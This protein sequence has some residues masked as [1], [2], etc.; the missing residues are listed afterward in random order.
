MS[1]YTEIMPS[2]LGIFH[3]MLHQTCWVD[4]RKLA[5]TLFDEDT[6]AI[7][8]DCGCNNGE[9][10]IGIANKIRAKTIWGIDIRKP[11]KLVSDNIK[12]EI[13][14]INFPIAF[15]DNYFD[16]I[17]ASNIIEHLSNTDTFLSEMHRMLKPNGYVIITTCNLSAWHNIGF[18]VLGRQPP[19]ADVSD[20]YSVGILGKPKEKYEIGPQH[21]RMFTL[22]ALTE[23]LECYDFMVEKTVGMGYYP[24][25]GKMAKLFTKLDKLH[26]AYIAVKARKVL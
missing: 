3:S 20:K 16:V 17:N 19:A 1:K 5:L 25:T 2:N 22:Q 10:T 4:A 24:F 6:N 11:E 12:I 13:A 8:C 14:D 23:L 7:F 21:R 26:S 18:L 9:V 15:P